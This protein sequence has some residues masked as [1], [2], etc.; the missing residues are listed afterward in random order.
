LLKENRR[1]LFMG[2]CLVFFVFLSKMIRRGA[3]EK[4]RVLTVILDG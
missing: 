2:H 4:E 3:R 1:T